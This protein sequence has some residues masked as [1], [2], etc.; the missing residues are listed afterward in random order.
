MADLISRCPSC[1]TFVGANVNRNLM[2][3]LL[4]YYATFFRVIINELCNKVSLY[5]TSISP[6]FTCPSGRRVYLYVIIKAMGLV[7]GLMWCSL[8]HVIVF[9]HPSCFISVLC[10]SFHCTA[11]GYHCQWATVA[12]GGVLLLIVCGIL[13]INFC[14]LIYELFLIGPKCMFCGKN[15]TTLIRLI[16]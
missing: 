3:D 13:C 6:F 1:S 14:F 16:L 15:S 5:R 11:S 10:A 9:D 2:M 8:I 4:T 7:S 12:G